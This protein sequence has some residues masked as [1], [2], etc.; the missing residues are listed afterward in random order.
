M[1]NLLKLDNICSVQCIVIKE[2]IVDLVDR[3]LAYYHYTCIAWFGSV[4]AFHKPL[5]DFGLSS[6]NWSKPGY[7]V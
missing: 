3:T 2:D 6:V 4:Y 7:I 5:R 1:Y